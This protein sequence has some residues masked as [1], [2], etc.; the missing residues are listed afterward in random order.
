VVGIRVALVVALVGVGAGCGSDDDGRLDRFCHRV[1]RYGWTPTGGIGDD[2]LAL[3][4]EAVLVRIAPYD[5]ADEVALVTSSHLAELDGSGP[6]IP[7]S[8]LDAAR[9]EV[10]TWIEDRCG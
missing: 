5:I 2:D 9:A 6:I 10:D 4:Q 3:A 8:R 1:E 7:P